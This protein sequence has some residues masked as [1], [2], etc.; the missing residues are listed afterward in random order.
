MSAATALHLEA[1]RAAGALRAASDMFR[2]L[3]RHGAADL[4]ARHALQLLTAIRDD[5]VGTAPEPIPVP[6]VSDSNFGEFIEA[7]ESQR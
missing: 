7:K 2:Q 3:G 6:E 1:A 4:M 5:Q